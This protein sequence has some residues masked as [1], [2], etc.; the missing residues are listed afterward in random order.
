MFDSRTLGKLFTPMCLGRQAVS[1]LRF[2]VGFPSQDVRLQDSGQVVYTD[3]PWS[4]S[5]IVP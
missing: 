2:G 4:P 3:V 1:F 5:G